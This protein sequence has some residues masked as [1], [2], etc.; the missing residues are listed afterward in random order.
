MS[1]DT[2]QATASDLAAAYGTTRARITA[3]LADGQGHANTPVPA[4]PAWTVSDLCAHLAGVPADLVAR[5]KPGADIQAWVDGHVA[6]RKARP[7]AELL[8]EWSTSRR[9]SRA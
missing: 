8:A 2:P 6:E 4:C 5:R 9:P 3:L 7:V 1:S